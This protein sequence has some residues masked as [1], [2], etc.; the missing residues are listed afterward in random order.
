MVSVYI[1]T[2]GCTLSQ[3]ES[4]AITH[5]LQ[6]HRLVEKPEDA[7]VIVLHTCIVTATTERKILKRIDVLCGHLRDRLLIITGC[8]INVL[9]AELR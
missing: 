3:S 2:Y 9:S 7:Q 5:A 6:R 1:E 4:E 8:A